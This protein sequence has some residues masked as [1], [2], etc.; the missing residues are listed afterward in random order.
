[1]ATSI[2]E[3][4]GDELCAMRL[5][6]LKPGL[7]KLRN[8]G[9]SI[10]QCYDTWFVKQKINSEHYYVE[11]C[12]HSETLLWSTIMVINNKS[13][14]GEI[15]QGMHTQLTQGNTNN[16]LYQFRYDFKQWQWSKHNQEAVN[17]IKQM[18]AMLKV[19]VE[20]QLVL[21][22]TLQSTFSHG[23]L[24]GYFETTVWP[25]KKIRF[26]D[27]NRL[28]ATSIPTPTSLARPSTDTNT[29]SGVTAYAG[30][31]EGEV[32][33]VNDQNLYSVNFSKGNIL[34]C[35]NTDVRYLPYMSKAAAIVTN[36]GSV[37]SHAAIVARELK[38]PCIIGTKNATTMLKDGDRVEVNADQGTVQKV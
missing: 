28:L 3:K 33:I 38:T 25:D 19:P 2:L 10:R 11:L 21:R 29:I 7:P 23:Y 34:I 37:L 31:V 26:I 35:D 4:R 24:M 8:R 20:K 36:R 27:Y 18:L 15:I 14:F 9:L 17:Y 22:D 12:P 5:V 6:P 16:E 32:R 1:V 13:V 30:K